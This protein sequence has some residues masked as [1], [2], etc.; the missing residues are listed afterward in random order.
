MSGCVTQTW[1]GLQEFEI[2]SVKD[3]IN[4]EI[5]SVVAHLSLLLVYLFVC[6][7]FM[8]DPF[9]INVLAVTTRCTRAKLMVNSSSAQRYDIGSPREL[10]LTLLLVPPL[11]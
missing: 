11:A 4:H 3:E 2:F 7:F 9:A 5:P 8:S 6:L 1:L 10:A